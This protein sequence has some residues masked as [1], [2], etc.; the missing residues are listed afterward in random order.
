M[1]V[2][3]IYCRVSTEDQEKQGTSLQTQLEACLTYCLDKGYDVPHYFNE[4]YS[5][6]ILTRP[7]LDE[8]RELVRSHSI[9]VVVV[10]CLD[11]LSRDPTHGV[12]LT[13]EFEK[14]HVVFETVAESSDNSDMGKLVSY[15]RG[16]ASKVEAE[17]IK[18]RTGRGRKA[19]V[20]MGEYPTGAGVG[21]YGYKWDR[22]TK[23]RI[24]IESEAKVVR[25]IFRALADGKRCS[26]VAIVL[27]QRNIPTK[28]HCKWTQTGIY[29]MT[30]NPCYI[31]N[32]YYW[33]SRVSGN[34][35]IK[36]PETEWALLPDV[37]PP[38]I[39]KNLFD[40]I[41][42]M[43]QQK[44]ELYKI[45]ATQEFPLRG[46]AFCGN[47][48]GHLGNRF[49]SHEYRYYRC[50]ASRLR[51]KQNRC[52]VL[53]NIRADYLENVVWQ[54]LKTVLTNPE[55]IL[56]G[57]KEQFDVDQE[58]PDTGLSLSK[59]IQNLRKKI[60]DFDSQEKRLIKL[61][62]Y[63]ELNQDVI[64]EELTQL[65]KAR[66]ANK[67]YLQNLMDRQ[68]LVASLSKAEPK[69]PEYY[70]ALKNISDIATS[71]EKRR[72]LDMLSI[73]VIVEI[74]SITIEGIVALEEKSVATL[75]EPS[76]FASLSTNTDKNNLSYVRLPFRVRIL[77]E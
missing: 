55:L 19:H 13:Q 29:D 9:N 74:G 41:Q 43:R 61:F 58:K 57:I 30:N 26:Q 52:K 60:T 32:T 5:G 38:I 65:K 59:E 66:E 40:N 63:E 68:E 3:A 75:G 70:N 44:R 24:P 39:S 53:K 73:K 1:T 22:E 15:V 50:L 6:L 45:K 36:C 76:E 54:N 62:R 47:C 17:K 28:M 25:W 67:L 77:S 12:I 10:Y 48:R 33:K 11:R 72:I 21:L 35:R 7:K 23:K 20:K 56:A 46:Y 42:N 14:H 8:L 37:T 16:Y 49:M 34:K 64:L 71:E 31:G 51:R 18:E 2:A 27:N 69:L 4:A